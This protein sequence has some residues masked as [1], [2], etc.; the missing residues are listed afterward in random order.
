MRLAHHHHHAAK[1]KSQCHIGSTQNAIDMQDH[2]GL[3]QG[4]LG[5]EAAGDAEDPSAPLLSKQKSAG[6]WR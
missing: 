2:G 6:F 3:R 1:L 4:E 5:T